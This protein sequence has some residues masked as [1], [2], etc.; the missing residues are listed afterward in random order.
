MTDSLTGYFRSR[1]ANAGLDQAAELLAETASALGWDLAAFHPDVQDN[2]LVRGKGGE[3][4]ARH[5]GWSADYL[6]GWRDRKVNRFCPVSERCQRTGE[7]FV[8]HADAA[9]ESWRD[10]PL[11]EEHRQ[12]LDYYRECAAGALTVPVHR[13]GARV[14]YV[15]WFARDLKSL[16]T[17]TADHHETA[18]LVSHWLIQ[19]VDQVGDGGGAVEADLTERLQSLTDRELECL[20]WAA[21]GKTEEEVGMIIQRSQATARFHLRNAMRKLDASNRTHAVAK[22][23]SL[24]LIR[25]L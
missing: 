21:R 1:V 9:A 16:R 23:C 10:Q 22:A 13:P 25:V 4:V 3:Y 17:L 7:P 24:G 20:F 14:G 19:H 5:M 8:W 12:A 11:L 2:D 6:S 15:S 18:Y